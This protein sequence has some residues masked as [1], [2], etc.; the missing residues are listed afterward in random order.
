MVFHILNGGCRHGFQGGVGGKKPG[1]HQV[2]PGIRT[3]GRQPH[4]DHQFVIL[5]IMQ[6]AHGF[7]IPGFQNIQNSLYFFFHEH[8]SL[9]LCQNH[10][11]V[12][13][14]VIE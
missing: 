11:G 1:G 7:R 13:L 9:S 8:P 4:G 14:P 6:G 5:F 2:D 3:L 12:F 10:A